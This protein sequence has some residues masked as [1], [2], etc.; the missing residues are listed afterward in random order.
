MEAR[1]CWENNWLQSRSESLFFPFHLAITFFLCVGNVPP[2]VN[3][4]AYQWFQTVDTDRSG[5]INPKELKQ[6]LVN[7]NWSAFNDETCFMMISKSHGRWTE[8]WADELF[9]N[10]LTGFLEAEW[11]E[12]KAWE[13][14]SATWIAAANERGKLPRK[15]TEKWM[16]EWQI[17]R[18]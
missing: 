16:K 9:F 18:K 3:P 7:S 11:L 10:A 8:R 12:V 13:M 2:G 5:F 4:E 14:L 6:A 1:P 15:K 17:K